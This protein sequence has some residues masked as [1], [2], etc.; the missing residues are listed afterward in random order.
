MSADK[1]VASVTGTDENGKHSFRAYEI[2][3]GRTTGP[4]LRR[5]FARVMVNGF[6]EPEGAV[7]ENGLIFGTY[8]HGLFADDVM[9]TL[10]TR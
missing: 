5:P 2:H 10:L 7:S 4:D 9:R 3:M 6:A 8:L 1:R